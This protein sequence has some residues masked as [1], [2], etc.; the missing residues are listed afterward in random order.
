[1][2]PVHPR[3]TSRAS[4]FGQVL[5]KQPPHPTTWSCVPL[6]TLLPRIWLIAALSFRVHSATTFALI[7]FMYNI[8]AFRGFLMWGLL[9]SCSFLCSCWGF[10][11]GGRGVGGGVGRRRKRRVDS[12]RASGYTANSTSLEHHQLRRATLCEGVPLGWRKF[13]GS[14]GS[15]NTKRKWVYTA[16][17][18]RAL[19]P[20]S[21]VTSGKADPTV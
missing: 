2:A 14:N 16:A 18:A 15:V 7:S 9:G 1:M 20:R 21:L 19:R 12:S 17:P 8:N 3:I 11:K 4:A 10:L 6:L 13:P 5:M